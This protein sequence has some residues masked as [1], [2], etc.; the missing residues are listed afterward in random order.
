M[1]NPPAT[2]APAPGPKVFGIGFQKTGTTSLKVALR[3]LG[4]RVTGPDFVRE[5]DLA[6]RLEDLARARLETFDAVQDNPWPLLYR[7]LDAWY[8]GSRFVLT[9]RETEAWYASALRHFGALSTPMRRLIYGEAHGAPKD[10]RAVWIRRY[11]THNAEVMAYFRDRPESL[12]VLR[13]TE[14]EGW[15][16][17]CPFLGKRLRKRAFP[18]AN[19]ERSEGDPTAP[20]AA[21]PARRGAAPGAAAKAKAK[22]GPRRG[23]QPGAGDAPE[24]AAAESGAPPRR[25]DA[26][27]KRKRP[28]A[29]KPGRAE[30]GAAEAIAPGAAA[31]PAAAAKE[32]RIAARQAARRQARLKAP[33][34]TAAGDAAATRAERRAALRQRREARADLATARGNDTPAAKRRPGASRDRSPG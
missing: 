11:E 8:P 3:R 33:P 25:P 5:P 15:E 23:A 16:K 14:G 27:G 30:R 21:R 31:S 26:V 9:V 20:A 12:L 10:N 4:Y 7:Q 24:A 32:A 22:A 29:G 18:H 19:A 28:G 1:P 17:L 13:I 6:A 34:A 2:R